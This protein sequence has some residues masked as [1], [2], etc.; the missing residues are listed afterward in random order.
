MTDK[1]DP[2]TSPRKE[3]RV[4]YVPVQYVDAPM[5]EDE[6]DL[7]D[8]IETIW[9]SRKTI[10]ISVSIFLVIG[11]FHFLTG[12][13]EYESEAILIQEAQ[14]D[15]SSNLRFLQQIGGFNIGG[16]SQSPGQISSSLYPRIVESV[17]FQ[18]QL[19]QNEVEFETMGQRMTLYEYFTEYYEPPFRKKVYRFLRNYTIRLPITIYQNIKSLFLAETTGE[20]LV[21]EI[22]SGNNIIQLNPAVRS[23]IS[24]MRTRVFVDFDGGLIVV[25]TRL[26]DAS[27][28][29]QVN[30]L[31][32]E[33]IQNFVID[34]R[35]EKARQNLEY[36][37]SMYQDAKE[38][39][40]DAQRAFAIFQDQNR[41]Q[42]TAVATTELERLQDER[43]L[44]FGIYNSFAQRLEEARLRLQE[45]TPVFSQ[46]QKSNLPHA[47]VKSSQFIVIASILLGGFI[48][49]FWIF[50]KKVT[51]TIRGRLI[52]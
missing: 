10:Y 47:P 50:A 21:Y 34:Y 52:L 45:D 12:P 23:A 19:L 2:N 11:L 33:Q 49:I 15:M 16:G 41:G 32:I 36:V 18:H 5:N 6:I 40:E 25:K 22:D 37:E 13:E 17:E 26:P 1:N 35:S 30:S 31:L 43:N 46:L 27:A 20:K 29:A 3:E 28:V 51:D 24:E 8:L 39:Y 4:Q 44:T 7:F 38:R 14:Q 48:G 9:K 42:L